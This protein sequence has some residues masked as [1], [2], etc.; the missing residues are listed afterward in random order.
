MKEEEELRSQLSTNNAT[1]SGSTTDVGPASK[2][3]K[4][5]QCENIFENR[6]SRAQS[7]GKQKPS[8]SEAVAIA[9]N[10]QNMTGVKFDMS[11]F[12]NTD[13]DEKPSRCLNTDSEIKRSELDNVISIVDSRSKTKRSK[14]KRTKRQVETDLETESGD[15]SSSSS[16]DEEV[17]VVKRKNPHKG[18]FHS[19]RYDKLSDTKL[20]SNEW[21]AHTA[22][23]EALGME[24][25]LSDL[26]FNLLFAGELEIIAS[27][28]ISNKE[29]FSR[30]ELLKKLSY[31]HEVLTLKD[32]LAQYASFISKVEKG[33]SKW[34]S[35]KD[36]TTF[37]QQLMYTVS[38]DRARP[39]QK[40][41]IKFDKGKINQ[42]SKE[43]RKKY[44]LDYNKGTCKLQ[45]PHEGSLNGSIVVKYHICK[46]CLI[47]EGVERY[48]PSKDC[49]K[50]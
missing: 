47:E 7:K 32:I 22:L 28:H 16:E 9:A 25:E 31:K 24:K 38:I 48:H 15:D 33:K 5:G 12:L 4:Y 44:C 45:G 21:Y 29:M 46:K 50:K 14:V 3:Q 39:E 11:G 13:G 1:T 2:R 34:G 41:A 43:E 26:S 49:V 30:I 40:S 17:H 42:V 10:L 35:K 37:E 8:D 20:V 18:K 19:G 36:L 27:P 6:V 23:D